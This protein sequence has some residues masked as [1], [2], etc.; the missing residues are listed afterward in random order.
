MQYSLHPKPRLL[1]NFSIHIYVPASAC[2]GYF[3]QLRRGFDLLPTRSQI[4][5]SDDGYT[6]FDSCPECCALARDVPPNG[7]PTRVLDLRRSLW[8]RR[9]LSAWGSSSRLYRGL[10]NRRVAQQRAGVDQSPDQR[11][12]FHCSS[13]RISDAAY[14]CWNSTRRDRGYSRLLEGGARTP[15]FSLVAPVTS[16]GC[17]DT[18]RRESSDAALRA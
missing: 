3:H 17:S 12:H 5:N 13:R 7:D 2:L 4:L 1:S 8:H 14:H 15:K 9:D 16:G 18:L 11:Y 10:E 6:G